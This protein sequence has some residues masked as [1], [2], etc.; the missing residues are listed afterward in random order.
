MSVFCN[1]EFALYEDPDVIE[2]GPFA[3]IAS[4]H[5]A[6]ENDNRT[7]GDLAL[8]PGCFRFGERKADEFFVC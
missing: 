7:D 6:V 2:R 5:C 3:S 8:K 4:D 1:V